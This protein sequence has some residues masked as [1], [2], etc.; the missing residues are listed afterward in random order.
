MEMC[1]PIEGISGRRRFASVLLPA[2]I[3]LRPENHQP[4]PPT[5]QGFVTT[6]SQHAPRHTSSPGA[7]HG[8]DLAMPLTPVQAIRAKCIDC[9]GG[10]RAE[11]RL[12]P[13]AECPL[14]PFRMGRNPN[15][16]PRDDQ[17]HQLPP[18]RDETG[19]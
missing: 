8:R 18:R 2:E 3:K 6:S 19:G 11:V 4:R 17:S 1:I 16:K 9:S 13:I 12:C 7:S 10:Q 15:R 5:P 14:Y